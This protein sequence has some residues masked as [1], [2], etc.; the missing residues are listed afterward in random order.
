MT[1]L[2]PDGTHLI[3]LGPF[4][5]GSTTVQRTLHARRD[6][7]PGHGVGF[8]ADGGT[9]A[10]HAGW[11]AMGSKPAMGRRPATQEDWDRYVAEVA[12]CDQPRL[13]ISNEEFSVADAASAARIVAGVGGERPHV[14]YVVRGLD[15]LLPSYY[16]E[17]LKA[18][19][20]RTYH[21]WLEDVFAHDPRDPA[22][23]SGLWNSYD[24][25]TVVERWL[26]AVEPQEMTLVVAHDRDRS[27]LPRIF[28]E[29]LG[30]PD[31][32]FTERTANQ[33]MNWATCET[34][35]TFNARWAE[36]GG[37]RASYHQLVQRGL[38]TAAARLSPDVAAPPL[39]ALP[40]WAHDQLRGLAADQHAAVLAAADRGVRVIG[41]DP[42]GLL[43][44][45]DPDDTATAPE[46]LGVPQSADLLHGLYL[47]ATERES[48]LSERLDTARGRTQDLKRRLRGQR[49]VEETSARDLAREILRRVARRGLRPGRDR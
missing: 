44:L 42:A 12:A 21:Q 6:E 7:L 1:L 22:V 29:L 24:V 38:V 16:Q 46:V 10:R 25:G 27:Q 20:A 9:R 34:L 4:K 8:P 17:R 48:R 13:L 39:P 14:V 41:A 32:F 45:R 40:S 2:L 49:T 31:D 5:T 33:S 43:T 3:H 19:E 11:W 37:D 47:R 26:G 30:L 23:R 15:R 36:H 28:S 35:R 18:G